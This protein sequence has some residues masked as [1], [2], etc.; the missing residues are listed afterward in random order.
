MPAPDPVPELGVELVPPLGALVP[1]CPMFVPDFA[2][3][4]GPEPVPAGGGVVDP[5]WVAAEPGWELGALLEPDPVCAS[6][7]ATIAPTIPVVAARAIHRDFM[8][9]FLLGAMFGWRVAR[10]SSARRCSE[11]NDDR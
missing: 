5:G 2:F 11:A 1:D 9:L 10:T 3:P 4:V 6:A 8:F 7:G